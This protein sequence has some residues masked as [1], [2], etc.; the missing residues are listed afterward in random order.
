M[1]AVDLYL[2]QLLD[3]KGSDIH[4]TAGQPP[5]SRVD[6]S[7]IPLSGLGN[8]SA[9]TIEKMAKEI[10]P[11]Y[12]LADLRDYHDTDFSYN[13]PDRNVRFRVNVFTD[14]KG[15][16]LVARAL[17]NEL[18]TLK[19]LGLPEKLLDFCK[20]SKGLF[21]VT[22]PTGS[23]KSTSLAAMLDEI[24]TK[25]SDHII[26]IEDP[27]EYV[28]ESKKC[29][30]NQREVPRQAVSFA[31]ALRSALREDPDV[32]LVGEMRD[33]ETIESAIELAETGHLV[34]GTLHTTTAYS[35][36]DRII[37][38][39]PAARQAQIRTMLSGSLRGVLAQVLCRRI[40]G[41]RV[42]ATELLVVTDAVANMIREGSV[43]QIPSVMQT[44]G[45][46]GMHLMEDSLA[47][48]AATNVVELAEARHHAND[49]ESFEKRF[50]ALGGGSPASSMEEDAD[51]F[52][53]E[54][55]WLDGE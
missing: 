40:G 17:N 13:Y 15:I 7:M 3:Q 46:T 5:Y 28:H 37:D 21:V 45:A 8:L 48:L 2:N 32:V 4:L 31:R 11:D 14:C 18:P 16:G 26:T 34:L 36:V 52:A 54:P 29:L 44:G 50:S 41:G 42:A 6:G 10:M 43:H 35:A 25:R 53:D 27:V 9:D 47:R 1:P 23:G 24:N 38:V 51:F 55:D 33:L 22:G 12:A 30:V 39:F 49:K 19:E 20:L